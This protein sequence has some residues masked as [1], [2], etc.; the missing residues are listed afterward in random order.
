MPQKPV[1]NLAAVTQVLD[2]ARWLVPSIWHLEDLSHPACGD[3]GDLGGRSDPTLG[4]WHGDYDP[5]SPSVKVVEASTQLS[6][7]RLAITAP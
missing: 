2:P 4:C 1:E 3:F 5:G 7:N 6:C